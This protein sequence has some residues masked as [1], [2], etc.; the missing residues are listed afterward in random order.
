MRTYLLTLA[1]VFSGLF[2]VA[3]GA[4]Q[5]PTPAKTTSDSELYDLAYKFR[6]DQTFHTKVIHLVTVETTIR[7]AT[8]VAKTRSVSTKT[9]KILNVADD[10]KITFVHS[11]DHVDMWQSVTGRQEVKYNSDTDKT[12]PSGYEL[13]AASVG[14]PLATVTM[15][16]HGRVLERKNTHSQFNPG[17]G[18][19]TIPLP[20]QK[21]KV[22]T[23]WTMP[24]E[25]RLKQDNG[26]VKKIQ[27]QQVYRLQKVETGVATIS[28]ET[29]VIT[30]VNDPKLKSELVQ[31]L[32]RGTIKFDL[33]AGRLMHKQMD[34]TET[35]LGFNGADS[36][37]EYLA[38]F[39][40]EPSAGHATAEAP[41]KEP[42]KSR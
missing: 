9:W 4:A 12:P 8:Q 35:V 29:Q 39:T 16:R 3:S 23:K 13:V 19:L 42:A 11:V 28:I 15:D 37:M 6:P 24:D 30:P 32:Q 31:R 38:R 40:E 25:V 26:E 7:G 1:A 10:G 2:I 33:D 17:I 21:V 18:E 36:Q 5:E 22:G 34:M 41:S 14:V 27:V 20:Q